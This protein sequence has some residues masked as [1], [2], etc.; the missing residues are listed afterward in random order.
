[1]IFCGSLFLS[2]IFYNASLAVDAKEE[3]TQKI[4]VGLRAAT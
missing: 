3:A 2:S 1:M 4:E